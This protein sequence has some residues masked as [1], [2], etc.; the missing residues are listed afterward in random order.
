MNS[1]DVLIEKL[2]TSSSCTPTPSPARQKS[3]L[4]SIIESLNIHFWVILN[5]FFYL[6]F[7]IFLLLFYLS[8][9]KD[10]L[11]KV[12]A[13]QSD[14]QLNY[15]RDQNKYKI[16]QCDDQQQSEFVNQTCNHL[17]Q[18]L[19]RNPFENVPSVAKLSLA[20]MGSLIQDFVG[21]LNYH[22]IAVIFFALIILIML[23]SFW[24]KPK[25]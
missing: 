14:A 4:N 21:G 13:I 5:E 19:N 20:Y 22:T 7:A 17:R 1:P 23:D 12:K 16:N 3:S 18:Q 25:L 15:T 10:Q 24:N 6:F 8:I 11:E 9:R 2:S